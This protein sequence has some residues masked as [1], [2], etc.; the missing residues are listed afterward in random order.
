MYLL[1]EERYVCPKDV[2]GDKLFLKAVKDLYV[3]KQTYRSNSWPIQC[4]IVAFNQ[5]LIP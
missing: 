4:L 5:D 3:D 2:N 1:E